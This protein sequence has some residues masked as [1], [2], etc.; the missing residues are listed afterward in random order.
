MNFQCLE[1]PIGELRVSENS[2][3]F[4]KHAGWV[5]LTPYLT[6]RNHVSK[7]TQLRNNIT[8]SSLSF[9][10]TLA[11]LAIRRLN[12]E[13]K[14]IYLAAAGTK[15]HNHVASCMFLVCVLFVF[16]GWLKSNCQN[17][18]TW[19]TGLCHYCVIKNIQKRLEMSFVATNIIW[20][21]PLAIATNSSFASSTNCF[22]ASS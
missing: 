8:R 3:A 20:G 5:C 7:H 15:T 21:H 6:L 17:W 13:I 9:R 16:G 18:T 19:S 22:L 2:G 4:S 1:A 12:I 10:P 14:K 11:L